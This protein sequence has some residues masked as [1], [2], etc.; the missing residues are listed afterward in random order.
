MIQFRTVFSCSLP[1]RHADE[2][3]NEDFSLVSKDGSAAAI[4]DG[5]ADSYDSRTLARLVCEDWV[6]QS[7]PRIRLGK[8]IHGYESHFAGRAMGWADQGAFERGSFATALGIRI[9]EEQIVCSA[10]GDSICIFH[11]VD[12]LVCFPISDVAQLKA[13]PTLLSSNREHNR[14]LDRGK[15]SHLRWNARPGDRLLLMTDALAAWFLG[16]G[17]M[18]PALATLESFQD[19]ET[20]QIFAGH[21]R[22]DGALKNDDTTL[23]HLEVIDVT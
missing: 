15:I 20:F 17:D 19:N 6:G 12:R 5:A 2:G 11:A 22:D 3:Y 7:I 8:I 18:M 23:V 16:S 14:A 13:R 4:S 9:S 21:Q 10:I 1:K